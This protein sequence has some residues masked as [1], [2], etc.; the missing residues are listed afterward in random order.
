MDCPWCESSE[1][2]VRV[3]E[4]YDVETFFCYGCRQAMTEV[5]VELFNTKEELATLKMEV[6]RY[7]AM[8]NETHAAASLNLSR[9]WDT[10]EGLTA[11]GGE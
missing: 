8:H 5:D 9:Q 6:R 2:L 10:L 3:D 7:M 1:E 4:P 11:E